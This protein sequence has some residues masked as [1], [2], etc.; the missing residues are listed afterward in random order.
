MVLGL[1][2]VVIGVLFLLRNLD[3]IDLPWYFYSWQ[4]LLIGIGAFNFLTG[5][6]SLGFIV[7]GIGIVFLFREILDFEFYDLWPVILIIIGISFFFGNRRKTGNGSRE[8]NLDVIDE[9]AVLGGGE[10]VITSQNFQGGKLTALFAGHEVDL[11]GS[12]LEPGR[13]TIEIFTM[14]GG[15]EIKVPEDWTVKS[16]VTPI[17]GGFSDKRKVTG[18]DPERVLVLKGTVLFGGIEVTN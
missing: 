9:M 15:T 12:K 16:E 11:R 17:L 2:L 14:F 6:R 4:M 3:I 10:R 7:A 13:Q 5:N 18:S 8:V 1:F